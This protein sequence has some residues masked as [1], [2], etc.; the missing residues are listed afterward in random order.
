M[1]TPVTIRMYN[2]GFGDCFLITVPSGTRPVTI[3]IDCGTHSSSTGTRTARDAAPQIVKDLSKGGRK[4]RIDIV[5]ATHRHKDHVS[6]FELRELWDGVEVGEVWLPWTENPR[7]QVAT[8]LRERMSRSALALDEARQLMPASDSLALAATII[9][10]SL[11]ND[12]AMSTLH[13]G[14]LGSPR[15]RFLSADPKPLDV[16]ALPNVKVHVLGPSRDPKVIR[17]LEPP[18]AE[19]WMRIAEAAP[20]SDEGH[21]PFDSDWA[22]SWDDFQAT[23]EFKDLRPGGQVVGAIRRAAADE[24]LLAAASLEKAVNGTSLMLLFEIGDLLLLFPGD[25]Q[26]GTWNAVLDDADRRRLLQRTTF[27]KI[28]HH[29]SHNAT[30]KAFIDDVLPR[31]TWAVLPFAPV[32]IWPSIPHVPL[33]QALEAKK[34]RVLRSD[35]P[36]EAGTLADVT[37]RDDISI[38]IAFAMTNGR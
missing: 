25:A 24:V 28:G 18:S 1:T 14:F 32:S 6:G 30:P 15:K 10:N 36:P 19:S 3:L 9:E 34:T 11:R 31:G 29:G 8:R 33:L 38:D 7:D 2:V 13:E 4:A 16:E 27:Y 17:D 35:A 20:E 23:E 22:I 12:S 37:V 26:W 5:V 21:R